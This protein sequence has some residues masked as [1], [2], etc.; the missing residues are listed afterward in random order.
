M[1]NLRYEQNRFLEKKKKTRNLKKRNIKKDL[2]FDENL[3]QK[4]NNR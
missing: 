1:K 4:P 3:T 2:I